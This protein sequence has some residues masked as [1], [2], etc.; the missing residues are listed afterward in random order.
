MARSTAATEAASTSSVKSIVPTTSERAAGS[1][2]NG[3][4]Y[5]VAS[6]HSYSRLELS[7][8]RFTA[9]SSPPD[10]L[11]QPIWLASRARVETAS[12]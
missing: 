1:A 6:A 5:A 8:V 11:I 2:T 4:V 9:Q 3:E 10:S 12:K 7:V